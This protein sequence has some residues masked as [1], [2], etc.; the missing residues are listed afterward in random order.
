MLQCKKMPHNKDSRQTLLTFKP[1]VV[2]ANGNE[3]VGILGTWKFDQELIRTVLAKMIVI[4]ELPFKFVEGEG[5]KN[6]ISAACPRFS[7]P[8]KWT[9][10]RDCFG[11]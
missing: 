4:D 10:S 6:F 2:E 8:S 3:P 9:I 11:S 7:I 5:F 1:D